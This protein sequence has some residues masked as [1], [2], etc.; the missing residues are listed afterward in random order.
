MEYSWVYVC[1]SSFIEDQYR[2]SFKLFRNIVKGA[3][4]LDFA[5]SKGSNVN[6]AFDIVITEQR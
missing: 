2:F 3:Q 4:G 5:R 1:E 6:K